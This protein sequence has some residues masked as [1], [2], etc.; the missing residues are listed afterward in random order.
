MSIKLDTFLSK[1][2]IA[3]I[4][5]LFKKGINTEAKSYRPI[6]LL[7]LIAKVIEKSIHD[8]TQDYPQ[9]LLYIIS[10]AL[11]QII[12]QIHVCLG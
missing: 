9:R 10:Q 3:K 6:S 4:K 11:E 8:Q 12:P 2:K 5:P 1:C 7:P